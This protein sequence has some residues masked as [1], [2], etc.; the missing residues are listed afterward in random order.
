MPAP[1]GGLPH[2]RT[3]LGLFKKRHNYMVSS[4]YPVQDPVGPATNLTAHGH[5]W[6]NRWQ[7]CETVSMA[8]ASIVWSLVVIIRSLEC[9]GRPHN[10]SWSPRS[11]LA[12]G[13]VGQAR[14]LG[15]A[16]VGRGGG[17]AH[18]AAAGGG[19]TAGDQRPAAGSF[20]ATRRSCGVDLGIPESLL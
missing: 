14:S 18:L 8:Q 13:V 20:S 1:N 10:S 7:T 3:A 16:G 6:G 9:P 4:S 11:R 5:F 2:F 17:Q 12:L 15:R 19:P